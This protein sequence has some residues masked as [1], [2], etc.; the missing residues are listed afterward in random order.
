[1]VSALSKVPSS[2]HV[3]GLRELH[4]RILCAQHCDDDPRPPQ[5]RSDPP[6]NL[7]TASAFERG[8]RFMGKEYQKRKDGLSHL[9]LETAAGALD[10]LQNRILRENG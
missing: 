4:D 7:Q 5:R 2:L 9:D 6:R 8:P 1:M 10:M 3:D